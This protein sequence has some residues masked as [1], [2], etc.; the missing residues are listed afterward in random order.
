M[1]RRTL[2]LS[3]LAF[4]VFSAFSFSGTLASEGWLAQILLPEGS[5]K[6]DYTIDVTNK[7]FEPAGKSSEETQSTQMKFEILAMLQEQSD[8]TI[9][10]EV[11]AYHI[12]VEQKLGSITQFYDSYSATHTGVAERLHESLQPV[13]ESKSNVKVNASGKILSGPE[14]E[15]PT[16]SLNNLVEGLFFDFPSAELK[17]GDSWVVQR[18]GETPN[19]VTMVLVEESRKVAITEYKL[20][21]VDSSSGSELTINTYGIISF[22][23]ETGMIQSYE[24]NQEYLTAEGVK[25]GTILTKITRN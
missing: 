9:D 7:R 17:S 2:S 14:S 24:E 6:Y 8:K 12:V 3:L 18:G 13:L 11:S 15:D 25:L 1:K 21:T 20:S 23:K 19:P 16:G 4:V 10:V 22:E 5:A